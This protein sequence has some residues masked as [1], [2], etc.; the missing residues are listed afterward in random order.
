MPPVLE[1]PPPL[2]R[3]K[4]APT[5]EDW[6]ERSEPEPDSALARRQQSGT[7]DT[8]P[9]GVFVLR[10]QFLL[11][12]EELRETFEKLAAEWEAETVM[13]SS[14][15]R[16]SMHPAYQRIIGLGRQ[17]LPLLLERLEAEP[18]H[19]FWALTAI[20]G[21]DPAEGTTTVEDAARAWVEWGRSQ[22]LVS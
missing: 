16:A 4:V 9:G 3:P 15:T 2:E 22:G 19:W 12:A 21:E 7:K 8:T 5:K 1:L 20:T 14:V 11:R 13:L 18:D 10:N 6:L 17:G